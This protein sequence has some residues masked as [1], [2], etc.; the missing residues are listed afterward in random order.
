MFAV[1]GDYEARNCLEKPT[2]PNLL[3]LKASLAKMSSTRD[4]KGKVITITGAASGIGLATA[5]Y[6]AQR[7]AN[8][9]L[10]DIAQE[11]LEKAVE[12]ITKESPDVRVIGTVLDISKTKE[13]EAWIQKTVQELGKLDG[14]ANLAAIFTEAAKGITE[15]ED[16]IWD[17]MIGV[18]L[19]GLMYC[20]R[21]QLKVI[22]DGGSIVN[23]TSVAG[24]VGSAQF[25]AYST[26]KHGVIGLT[27][28]AAREAGTRHVRV[29]VIC[30]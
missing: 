16:D 27:K 21:A 11:N 6:L 14:A 30:P 4:L 18:N 9:S 1:K 13:V 25:P 2:T 24:L 26:S 17:S 19:T 20:L 15:M 28:C 23:A 5:H 12:A 3:L 10:A 29:N 7:G 22:V 8:L